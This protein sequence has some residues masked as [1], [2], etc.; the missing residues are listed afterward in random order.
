MAARNWARRWYTVPL[1]PRVGAG[2]ADVGEAVGGDDDG[3]AVPLTP[4]MVW[5]C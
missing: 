3:S 1:L 2:V 4:P 5:W